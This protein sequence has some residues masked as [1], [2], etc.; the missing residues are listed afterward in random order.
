MPQDNP[1]G[2]HERRRRQIGGWLS[3]TSRQPAPVDRPGPVE[4][5]SEAP[6][7]RAEETDPFPRLK[8]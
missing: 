6:E 4:T 3:L 1:T 8:A 5:A 7:G 2:A